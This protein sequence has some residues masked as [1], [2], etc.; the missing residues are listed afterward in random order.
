[1]YAFQPATIASAAI[2]A[3]AAS[4]TRRKLAQQVSVA[5]HGD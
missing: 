5:A 1:L 2:S 3:A 4:S